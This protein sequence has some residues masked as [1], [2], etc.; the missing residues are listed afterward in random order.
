MTQIIEVKTK[1]QRK[2][3]VEYPLRLYKDNPNFVPPLYGDEM[4]IFTEK[5]IYFK[6]CKSVFYLAQRDGKTVGRI[7]GIIQM[8]Y[9]DVH[10]TKQA[11]FTRFDCEND[12]NTAKLLFD[13]VETWAKAQQ[14]QTLVGPLGYSDLEREGLLIEGFDYLST[15]EEQYNHAYYADLIENC[16]YAKDVDWVEFRLFSTPQQDER[17][18]KFGERALERH[19]LRIVSDGLNKRQIIK[20]YANGIFQC[21]DECYKDLYGTVPFTPEMIKQMV[22]QFMLIINKRYIMVVCDENDEVAAFGFCL[23]GIGKAVQKTGGKLTLGCLIRLL[24][25]VKN[26]DSIDLGLVG[27]MPKYRKSG[28]S[29]Y[30]MTVLQNMLSTKGVEYLETNLNLETNANIQTNWKHFDF[31]QHKRRRSYIKYLNTIE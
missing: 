13:A 16:G 29:A 2:E 27:I 10:G 26:P 15:F 6:T 7:Q 3:F 18:K 31:I 23:P 14:M 30:I 17:L 4:K 12:P 25:A 22:D 24:K 20:R 21:I 1:K 9:N 8:Q 11:R 28:L 5:N 19:N